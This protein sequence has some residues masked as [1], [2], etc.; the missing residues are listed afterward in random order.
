MRVVLV[1]HERGGGC[2]CV[3][4]V[5]GTPHF[6]HG[7]GIGHACGVF[8]CTPIACTRG[9][10]VPR[11]SVTRACACCRT[12]WCVVQRPH[13]SQQVLL[14]PRRV[15]S[16]HG[17]CPVGGWRCQ[18]QRGC[19]CVSCPFAMLASCNACRRC[20]HRCSGTPAC[21]VCDVCMRMGLRCFRWPAMC[22]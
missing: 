1:A 11:G 18:S 17:G 7:A 2:T 14:E 5:F 19:R 6:L 20:M 4:A 22:V 13:A 10:G 8:A 9:P 15:C 16:L 12:T 21:E 3:S